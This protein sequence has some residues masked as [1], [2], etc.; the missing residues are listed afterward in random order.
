M[1]FVLFL[2]CNVS[3]FFIPALYSMDLVSSKKK[4]EKMPVYTLEQLP[5]LPLVKSEKYPYSIGDAIRQKGIFRDDTLSS[6]ALLPKELSSCIVKKIVLDDLAVDIFLKTPF[7]DA[8]IFY[9][10]NQELIEKHRL[11]GS[12][13]IGRWLRLPIDKKNEL[14]QLLNK[15]NPMKSLYN[16][17]CVIDKDD[18]IAIALLTDE[19][20][21]EGSPLVEGPQ[22][23]SIRIQ[24]PVRY[25]KYAVGPLVGTSIAVIVTEACAAGLC[26]QE[27]LCSPLI[28]GFFRGIMPIA[29]CCYGAGHFCYSYTKAL[30]KNS[31]TLSFGGQ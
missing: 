28:T 22:D 27:G 9:K 19:L 16:D 3:C 5:Y 11:L 21:D 7:L 24:N 18:F 31:H 8:L 15:K 30:Q 6:L 17:D 1:N 25:Y 26:S 4:E 13:N 2:L 20:R 12:V 14:L 10:E 29:F 23:Y